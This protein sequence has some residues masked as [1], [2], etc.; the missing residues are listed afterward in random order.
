MTEYAGRCSVC[1]QLVS[2]AEYNG[3][4][5]HP[6]ENYYVDTTWNAIANPDNTQWLPGY[7]F[8]CLQAS[9]GVGRYQKGVHKVR[10]RYKVRFEIDQDGL[11]R[12][13]GGPKPTEAT[14]AGLQA[15]YAR[16]RPGSNGGPP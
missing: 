8:H 3:D 6:C 9:Q 12:H 14:L 2:R 13:T 7:R 1:R 4:Q 10:R 15:L 5:R 16:E 11:L